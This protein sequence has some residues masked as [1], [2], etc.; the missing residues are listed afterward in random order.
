MAMKFELRDLTEEEFQ[1]EQKAFDDHGAEF[2]NPLEKQQERI[3][4]VAGDDGKFVG[5]SSGLVRKN[6]NNYGTYFHLTDLLVEKV[7]RKQGYGKK[8]LQL[9]EDKI[10]ALGVKYIWTWTAEYEA[11][12]FYVKQGYSIFTRFEN[13]YQSGHSRVGLIKTL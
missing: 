12:K 1:I 8:L 2:G 13:Y 11:E 4:F 6:G 9:L 10:K 5:A 7:Y 3:G